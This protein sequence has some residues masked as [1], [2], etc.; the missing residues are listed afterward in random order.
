MKSRKDILNDKEK[1][2]EYY[3]KGIEFE[4]K[5]FAKKFIDTLNFIK[6][7]LI[8]ILKKFEDMRI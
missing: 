7:K 2:E 8:F 5:Y 4:F 6:N 1:F 3:K